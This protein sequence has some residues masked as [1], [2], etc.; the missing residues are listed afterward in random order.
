MDRTIA[1]QIKQA[2]QLLARH[3]YGTNEHER[4]LAL[5]SEAADGAGGLEAKWM[6]G[7]YYLQVN[8][9]PDARDGAARALIET[10]EAGMPMAVDRLVDLHLRGWGVERSPQ[11]ALE[12]LRRLADQGY[13]RAAWEAGYLCS[14]TGIADEADQA[15]TELARAC[16]LGYPF[17]YY[18]LGLRFALGAGTRRDPAFARALLQRAA[19]AKIPD[20][21]AAADALVPEDLHGE[22][23]TVWYTRLK[24]NLDAAHP[25]LQRL[26]P[27]LAKAGAPLVPGLQAIEAHLA[28]IDHPS[29]ALDADGRLRVVADGN[30]SLR[31]GHHGWQWRSEQPRVGICEGFATREECAH[32]MNK[33]EATLSRPGAYRRSGANDDAETVSFNGSGSPIGVMHT[34]P[35]V[36]TL[37]QRIAGMTDWSMDALEP[38]SIIRYQSGEQYRPH[39]DFFT[40]D[41]IESNAAERQDH[42]GQRIATFLLYLRAPESGGE[43]V[44][45]GSD[46][47]VRGE[48]G[49]GVIHYNVTPDGQQDRA[50]E[51][52]GRPIERGEKWLWRSTLRANP[53]DRPAGPKP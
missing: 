22:Q 37:E 39:V 11:R 38:C 50:S 45:H 51:H 12:L 40:D 2:N 41:Q 46:L 3:R 53:F 9:R 48:Q 29:I 52:S 20:A 15:C 19:D 30:A 14:E 24:A 27:G 43:T 26:Q 10:A 5:L 31:A 1:E 16:A 6:L 28:A 36:R 7:A 21:L 33:V 35:V 42:G 23:A 8:A 25:Q 32:L 34:D 47:T 18:S 13:P 17:A 4:G 49:M 44:Y